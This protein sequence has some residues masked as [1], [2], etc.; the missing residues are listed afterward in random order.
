MK[1]MLLLLLVSASFTCMGFNSDYNPAPNQNTEMTASDD[2]QSINVSEAN[3]STQVV[4]YTS[5]SLSLVIENV[6]R[7]E[8]PK[9]LVM[10][11]LIGHSNSVYKPPTNSMSRS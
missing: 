10:D 9:T 4:E 2:V 5:N 7:L 1:K 6:E 8:Y 3:V 11:T